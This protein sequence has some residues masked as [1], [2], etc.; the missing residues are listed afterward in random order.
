MTGL[1]CQTQLFDDQSII[2]LVLHD[3]V[4]LAVVFKV[5]HRHQL[6]LAVL[7]DHVDDSQIGGQV[8][9]IDDLAPQILKILCRMRK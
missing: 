4:A 9:I 6:D 2:R 3:E 1:R 5:A 8:N 7:A